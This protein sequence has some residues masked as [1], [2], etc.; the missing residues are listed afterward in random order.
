MK[1]KDCKGTGKFSE[2][3]KHIRELMRSV[4]WLDPVK[5]NK[6]MDDDIC[7]TCEG[8]GSSSSKVFRGDV[9]LQ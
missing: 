3:K 4:R 9:E 5:M 2:C 8:T 6:M 7:P 1:C